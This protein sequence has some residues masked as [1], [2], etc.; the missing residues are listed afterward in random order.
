M[1]VPTLSFKIST[2]GLGHLYKGLSPERMKVGDTGLVTPEDLIGCKP[3]VVSS[4]CHTELHIACE[5][6]SVGEEEVDGPRADHVDP[7]TGPQPVC[8]SLISL[9]LIEAL[10]V[11]VWQCN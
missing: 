3:V 10:R 6:H 9:C 7:S 4:F 8:D 2:F 11:V 5:V 1:A